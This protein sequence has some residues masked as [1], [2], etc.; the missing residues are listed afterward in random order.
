MTHVRW[1]AAQVLQRQARS[2]RVQ[3]SYCSKDCGSKTKCFE[4]M[5][6]WRISARAP[7]QTLAFYRSEGGRMRGRDRGGVE[8]RSAR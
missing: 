2:G 5:D 6:I 4:A 7:P 8:N 1:V 3:W